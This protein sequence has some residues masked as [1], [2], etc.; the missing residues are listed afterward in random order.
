M[1]VSPITP[2][3]VTLEEVRQFLG[4][5]QINPDIANN[6]QLVINSVTG[7]VFEYTRRRYLVS[8]GTKIVEYTRGRG[9]NELWL[10][11]SPLVAVDEVQTWPFHDTLG[12]TI[13]GPG[14]TLYDDEMYYDRDSG[15]VYLKNYNAPD[16]KNAAKV[17]YE[18]GYVAGAP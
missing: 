3:I 14:T 4:E 11:E 2:E 13:S 9:D 8:D 15:Q 10:N 18:A 1:A 6:L 17:T 16:Q 7:W 12:T 5:Q